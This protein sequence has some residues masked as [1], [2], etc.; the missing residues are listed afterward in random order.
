MDLP[1][2]WV[3]KAFSDNIAIG[4]PL[5]HSNGEIELAVIIR[6]L[7]S[8]QLNMILGGFFV[9]GAVV[10]G[11][12]YMDELMIFGPG[13][14][15]ASKE[16]KKAV[17]P[18]IVVTESVMSAINK[19]RNHNSERIRDN[20]A[21]RYDKDNQ[22]LVNYLDEIVAYEYDMGYPDIDTMRRHRDI[23]SARLDEFSANQKIAPKYRWVAQYH[24]SFC[25]ERS[26]FPD[27]LKVDIS[28]NQP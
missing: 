21:M 26:D 15:N 2:P 25:D 3:E 18:K 4:Y 23:V 20:K 28:W 27:E 22:Y 11:D 8:F 19:Q 10:I 9:R 12:L 6:R 14:L 17:V 16:E 24:N 7:G 5:V 13:L 1:E